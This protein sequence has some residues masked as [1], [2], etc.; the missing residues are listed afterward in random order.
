[1][2]NRQ[3]AST[4]RM[5]A[6]MMMMQGAQQ[7][8]SGSLQTVQGQKM[9]NA[10]NG[11]TMPKSMDNFFDSPFAN[12]ASTGATVNSVPT[13][14]TGDGTSGT[15]G[16]SANT[17]NSTMAPPTDLGMPINP[18][19]IPEGPNSGPDPG[20]FMAGGDPG[21]GGQGAGAAVGGE[22]TAPADQPNNGPTQPTEAPPVAGAN[23]DTSGALPASAGGGGGG[24]G[25]SQDNPE[26]LN[27]PLA[28]LLAGMKKDEP[29]AAKTD[30]RFFG[31]GDQ[32]MSA[33]PYTPY[34]KDADLMK[35]VSDRIRFEHQTGRVGG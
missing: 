14:I 20:Q 5:P 23:Y 33:I 15:S 32:N 4:A 7:I 25:S 21:A 28:M 24:R 13:A 12:S 22:S 11:F 34:G 2:E 6:V 1:M 17:D 8:I 31:S 29:N 26:S 35:R 19:P 27:N 16:A 3:A 30:I 18:N 9:I 10:A